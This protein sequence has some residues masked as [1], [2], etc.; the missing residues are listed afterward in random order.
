MIHVCRPS[1]VFSLPEGANVVDTTSRSAREWSRGLS[2]F[3]LGPVYLYDRYVSRNVE[4]AWQYSKV[5][6]CHVDQNGD[7]TTEYFAWAKQGWLK[8]RADRYPM[9]KGVKP[10]YS[11]WAG[12]KLGYVEARKKIYAPL[13]ETAVEDTEAYQR[14][15]K[16]YET[17]DDEE[18]WL[19]D[20]DAYDH[21][22][23]HMS[24]EDVINCETRKMG[25][26]FVLAMMLED[27]RVWLKG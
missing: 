4:N 9:G 16:L 24:L 26:G 10:L 17:Q 15:C 12:Q 25:H 1:Q 2:P 19:V 22:K 23:M 6:P 18:L 3:L 5:Y 27:N 20:F 8:K 11:F 21:V 14:L 7:P 13:Y